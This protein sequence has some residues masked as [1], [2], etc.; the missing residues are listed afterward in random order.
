MND[1]VAWRNDSVPYLEI[2]KVIM[3]FRAAASN[4]LGLN[5]LVSR[6]GPIKKDLE[7]IL[8]TSPLVSQN[9]E[10]CVHVSVTF[11]VF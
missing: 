9:L 4:K 8:F 10:T 1:I 6:A 5:A 3:T 7:D 2:G 11:W